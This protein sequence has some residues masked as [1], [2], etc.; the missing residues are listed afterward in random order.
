MILK[1][2]RVIGGRGNSVYLSARVRDKVFILI[3]V[4]KNVRTI[5]QGH[6]V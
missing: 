3:V 4:A 6:V 2:I 5:S 1:S